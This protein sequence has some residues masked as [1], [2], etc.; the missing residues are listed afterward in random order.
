[1]SHDP[2]EIYPKIEIFHS[3]SLKRNLLGF[4][5]VFTVTFYQFNATLLE[6]SINFFEERK[7]LLTLIK[8]RSHMV[9]TLTL[10]VSNWPILNG[11]AVF[12]TQTESKHCILIFFMFLPV[13][14]VSRLFS[15]CMCLVIGCVKY[16]C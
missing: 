1:M 9:V 14:F 4:V 5:N 3:I 15:L 13:L 2:S 6:K 11:Q 7:I 16:Q 10:T 12:L 8:V